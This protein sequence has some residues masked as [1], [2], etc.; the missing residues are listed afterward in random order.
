MDRRS[1][2]EKIRKDYWLNDLNYKILNWN[3]N[4]NCV[5]F[6]SSAGLD[7]SI[8]DF[9][10][11]NTI[12]QRKEVQRHFGKC[13]FIRDPLSSFYVDGINHEI[14]CIDKLIDYIKAQTS[15][16][17]V[18]IAGYSA[19]AYLALILASCMNNVT[20]VL[21]FSAV[22]SLYE[23]SGEHGDESVEK[24]Q[25]LFSHI[26]EERYSKYYNIQNMIKNI[27]FIFTPFRWT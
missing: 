23:W 6:I 17:N 25:H 20:R 5:V 24:N 2:K 21:A 4:H 14:D 18:I 15:G 13:I 3:S 22:A 26:K 27:L 9:Y 8:K 11:W 1:D 16:Y 12:S 7:L 10:E 19:G